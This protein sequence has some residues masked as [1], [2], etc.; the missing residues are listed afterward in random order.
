MILLLRLPVQFFV[1][2]GELEDLTF[3]NLHLNLLG[4]FASLKLLNF[5]DDGKTIR[6]TVSLPSKDISQ[7]SMFML[8][9]TRWRLQNWPVLGILTGEISVDKGMV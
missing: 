1:L 6:L 9:G 3:Q 8:A 5:F 2:V 4:S 7:S